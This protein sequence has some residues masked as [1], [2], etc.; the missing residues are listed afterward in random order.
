[1]GGRAHVWEQTKG[2]RSEVEAD[3][4]AQVC[5]VGC[6]PWRILVGDGLV[7]IK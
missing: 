6:Q 4:E 7:K 1:M 2:R 3:K 5:G